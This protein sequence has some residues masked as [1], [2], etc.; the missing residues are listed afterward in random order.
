MTVTE[1]LMMMFDGANSLTELE[2]SDKEAKRRKFGQDMIGG[3]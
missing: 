3:E 1:E 2:T